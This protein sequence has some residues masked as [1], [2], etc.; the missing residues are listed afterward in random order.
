MITLAT[1]DDLIAKK[2]LLTHYF[3]EKKWNNGELTI[4]ELQ[5]YAKEYF[6]LV[7][8]VPGMVSRVRDR[9]LERDPKLAALIAKNVA[10]E[11]EHIELWKKF[12]G[13]LGISEEELEAHQP[14]AKVVAAV[15]KLEELA[16]GSL[17]DGVT[18]MYAMERELPA[19]AKSKKDGLCK[20]YGIDSDE[21]HIY[22][23]EHLNE[24][25]HFDVWLNVKVDPERAKDVTEQSLA[26]QHLLL[27]GVCD[28][29]GIEMDCE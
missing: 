12:S 4:P 25:D 27:D 18:M 8:A 10:E 17:E 22:F 9:A 15:E 6:H 5:K 16:E 21:A 29:M 7:K 14:N 28:V 20:H 1:F 3:Y 24:A 23:D 19:I 26:A 2:S 13:S 11:E